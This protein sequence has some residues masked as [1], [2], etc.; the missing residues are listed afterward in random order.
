MRDIIKLLVYTFVLCTTTSCI[1]KEPLNAECDITAV[2]VDG[3]ILN[4]T[5]VI[6]NT[7][8]TLIVKNNVN[9]TNLAPKFELTEGSTI[10]PASGTAR[11]FTTPQTYMTTSQDGKWHKVYTIEVKRNESTSGSFE[12]SFENVRQA[13][14]LMGACSYDVFYEKDAIG[15][16][17]LTWASGNPGFALTLQGTTPATFP[18]FQ[19]DNGWSGKC[20]EMVTRATGTFGEGVKKPLAAGNLF[21]G[22]FDMTNAVNK[23]LEATQFG[24]PFTNI[25]QTLS[26]Y[27]KYTPG[28]QY[29]KMNPSTGKL[30]PVSGKVDECNVYAVFFEVT[31]GMEWLDGNNV[32]ADD[33][34]NIIAIARFSEEQRKGASDWTQFSLP[35]EYRPGKTI[36]PQKLINGQYSITV[37]FSSSVDGDYFSGAIGSTLLVDEVFITCVN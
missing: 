33:N 5:P 2:I 15:N 28:A 32:M 8:I 3:D 4:R 6:E 7:K 1:K 25:P 29:C 12:F 34:P 22:K 31:E 17:T 27:Y 19:S 37:V 16:E 30:E 26:G 18:T 21:I 36:D 23:P 35:F 20:V 13:T 10:E 14:A 11:D 9:V 24:T